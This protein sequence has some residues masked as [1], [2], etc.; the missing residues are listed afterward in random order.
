M[1]ILPIQLF[2]YLTPPLP[3]PLLTFDNLEDKVETLLLKHSF[4]EL[5]D[6]DL[7]LV[8]NIFRYYTSPYRK[9]MTFEFPVDL[10]DMY[11]QRRTLVTAFVLVHLM[12][13]TLIFPKFHC[14]YKS[15]ILQKRR[16]SSF[17]VP[18]GKQSEFE[19]QARHIVDMLGSVSMSHSLVI[20]KFKIG[21]NNM[22][23]T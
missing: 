22:G 17:P 11:R 1:Q 8:V 3:L 20:S 4:G 2:H 12:N 18:L 5:A 7:S 9:Y 16:A 10:F 13:R 21:T 6:H 14:K 23:K 19:S 15:W